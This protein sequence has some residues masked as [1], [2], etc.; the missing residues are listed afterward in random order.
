MKSNITK[1]IENIEIYEK[2]L[3]IKKNKIIEF[4]LPKEGSL[5]TLIMYQKEKKTDIKYPRKYNDIK[6]KELK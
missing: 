5:R 6:K 3:H 2:E 4:T 1:E